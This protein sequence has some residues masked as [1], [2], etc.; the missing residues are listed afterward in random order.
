CIRD[1]PACGVAIMQGARRQEPCVRDGRRTRGCAPTL[2]SPFPAPHHPAV[3]PRAANTE[4]G[5][6]ELARRAMRGFLWL[7]AGNGV[8]A[9]LKVV[10]LALL[11]RLLTP[12]DFGVLGAAMVVVWLSMLAT[13]LGVGPALVQRSELEER[14]IA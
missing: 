10:F 6:P 14:H 3:M 2:L 13:S 5:R 8:R 7:S 12:A 11:A 4:T 1:A 9:V